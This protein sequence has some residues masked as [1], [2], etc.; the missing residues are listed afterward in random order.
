LEIKVD[1]D[2]Q[3]LYISHTYHVPWKLVGSNVGITP[4]FCLIYDTTAIYIRKVYNFLSKY[5]AT[6]NR[7]LADEIPLSL[8]TVVGY[9]GS[10]DGAAKDVLVYR[11]GMPSRLGLTR[12][13]AERLTVAH[14]VWTSMWVYCGVW[15]L[16]VIVNNIS[17]TLA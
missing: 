10:T 9:Y 2:C 11:V 15:L 12:P 17:V 5:T 4:L 13:N 1:I 7:L 3:I 14:N 16:N 6:I 8:V